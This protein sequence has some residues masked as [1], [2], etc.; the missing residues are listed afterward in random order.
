MADEQNGRWTKAIGVPGLAALNK[1][2][3]SSYLGFVRLFS[4]LRGHRDLLGPPP[5]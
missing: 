5:R 2:G 4:Q 1:A 3:A